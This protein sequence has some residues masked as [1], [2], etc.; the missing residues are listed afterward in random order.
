MP[1]G[2]KKEGTIPTPLCRV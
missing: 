2:D 1:L